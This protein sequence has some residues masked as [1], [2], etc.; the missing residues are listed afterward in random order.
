MTARALLRQAWL[1][2]LVTLICAGA[3]G[4][5]TKLEHPVYRS[6]MK[7]VIGQADSFFQ[8]DVANA[9]EIYTQTMSDLVKSQVVASTVVDRLQIDVSPTVIINNLQVS[10]QPSA[11]VLDI[12]YDDTDPTRGLRTLEEVGSVF[13]EQVHD[14]LAPTFAEQGKPAIS[15][16]VFDP[17]HLLPGIVR[18]KPLLNLAGAA[19]IGLILGIL[20]ALVRIRLAR[21]AAPKLMP[22]ERQTI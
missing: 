5:Y 7:V 3:A 9:T 12:S 11:A 21:P 4:A 15:V 1:V 19:A 2:V 18:P 17:A 14:R 6:S 22:L 16:T 10:T 13:V 20:A 8:P